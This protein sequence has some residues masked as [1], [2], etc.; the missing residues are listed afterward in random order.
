[1]KIEDSFDD[2]ISEDRETGQQ[3]EFKGATLERKNDLKI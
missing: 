1:V 3:Y 2:D